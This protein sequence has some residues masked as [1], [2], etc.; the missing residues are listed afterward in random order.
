[1][2]VNKIY[3]N[4]YQDLFSQ[5]SNEKLNTILMVKFIIILS[6]L[7]ECS[8]LKKYLSHQLNYLLSLLKFKMT[9]PRE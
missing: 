7:I 5:Y 9:N 2:S 8:N 3:C 4:Y 6:I 1:M